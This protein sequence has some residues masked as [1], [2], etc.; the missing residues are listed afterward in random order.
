MDLNT[1]LDSAFQR[2][3]LLISVDKTKAMCF[4]KTPCNSPPLKHGDQYVQLVK[5]FKYW[6]QILSSNGS[7]KGEISQRVGKATFVFNQLLGGGIWTDKAIR[8]KTKLTI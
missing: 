4:S 1:I 8:R 5:Q 6:G 3:G 2:W 7:L